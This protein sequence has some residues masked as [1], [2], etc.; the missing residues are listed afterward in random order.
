MSASVA[1]AGTGAAVPPAGWRGWA[2][3][4]GRTWIF[5][6]QTS[7][8][9]LLALWVAFRLG[10][11]SPRTAMLTVFIVAQ[12]QTG[13]VL[14]KSFFRIAGTLAG[15]AFTLALVGVLAQQREP[16]FVVLSV[17]VGLCTAGAAHFRNFRAYGFV[18]AGYTACLIGFPAAFHPEAVFDIAVARVSEV[19]L[20]ILCAGVIA[21]V[22]L[23]QRLGP[24]LLANV[25]TR[26][27]DYA[28]FVAR[29]LRGELDEWTIEQ[30]HSR[31]AADIAGFEALRDATYFETPDARV[32][33]NRL[34]L[35]NADFMAATTTVH[36]LHQLVLRLGR[37]ASHPALDR[38][39]PLAR[40]LADRLAPTHGAPPESALEA[41]PVAE[42]LSDFRARLPHL[43]RDARR[44]L[45]PGADAAEL[46]D[47]DS[48]A[49]LL[50]RATG[51]LERFTR[52]YVALADPGTSD[53]RRAP[54]Y[55]P[56]ADLYTTVTSGARAV[57]ALLAVS[58]FWIE[59]AWP[60]GAA[61]ATT[62]CVC[63]CL[64][65]AA[66][67]PAR[68]VRTMSVGF[69]WGLLAAFACAFLVLPRLDGFPMLA[70]GLLPFMTVGARLAA[71]PRTTLIGAGYSILFAGALGIENLARFDPI[72]LLNDGF[73]QIAGA[74]VSGA[75]FSLLVPADGRRLARGFRQRLRLARSGRL[76]GLRHRFENG[77]R[78][79][80]NQ[81]L[82]MPGQVGAERS[83]VLGH[84]L[85]VLEA[86]RTVIEL[87][88]AAAALDDASRQ[89]VIS[90]VQ[91]VAALFA[92]PDEL[93]RAAAL[94]EV[95]RAT[96]RIEV[97]VAAAPGDG[98]RAPALRSCRAAL[99]ALR[100]LLLDEDAYAGLSLNDERLATGES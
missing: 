51:E 58:A 65:A 43:V 3:T 25:R 39:V 44:A 23:P 92:T 31:F 59:T 80:L 15:C 36:T 94:E 97:A 91:S 5:V 6:G 14:A 13:L 29:A 78:D 37:R 75:A 45:E 55:V 35:Y 42:R 74:L 84:A 79:L 22:V 67:T 18:L 96:E 68:A 100:V 10:L 24:A 88:D 50:Q 87:R 46:I 2:A 8:A 62:A 40:A 56:H 93:H 38:F 90:C 76:S 20:G 7:L 95:R 27:K 30:S 32:R 57:V 66:P 26:Y 60:N 52:S 34:R 49:E 98:P 85:T 71:N 83:R 12:P 53:T 54:R 11:G 9:A 41:V 48:A 86:G 70:T 89:Q 1:P 47:Y 69:A 82:A 28:R 64:F 21:D 73:A 17:W 61:A 16:F 33:N 72:G 63:C 99:H 19:L 77:T 4:G 81:L